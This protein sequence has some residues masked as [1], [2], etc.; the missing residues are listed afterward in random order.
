[1]QHGAEGSWG[2][3]TKSDDDVETVFAI[4]HKAVRGT[5]SPEWLEK[6]VMNDKIKGEAKSKTKKNK[7][8]YSDEI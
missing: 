2:L 1:M 3:Q 8:T 5:E 6:T 4:S 7:S